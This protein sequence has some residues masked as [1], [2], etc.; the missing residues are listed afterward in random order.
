MNQIFPLKKN[1]ETEKNIYHYRAIGCTSCFLRIIGFG[2][3]AHYTPQ[4]RDD[5]SGAVLRDGFK[6]EVTEF[7]NKFTIPN[8]F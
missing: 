8:V 1:W 7:I 2:I 5:G 6:F 3:A 4:S